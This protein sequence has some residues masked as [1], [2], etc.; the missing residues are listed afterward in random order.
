MCDS[1]W[2]TNRRHQSTITKRRL[3]L[4][5]KAL[6]SSLGHLWVSSDWLTS[7]P[8]SLPPLSYPSFLEIHLSPNL[9]RLLLCLQFQ[10][11]QRAM[12]SALRHF[13]QL[14]LESSEL[15]GR[16]RRMQQYRQ[17]LRPSE[18]EERDVVVL[19]RV[20]RC[21]GVDLEGSQV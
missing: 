15:R 18:N 6:C 11:S 8:R 2:I 20:K 3:S 16:G 9:V 12:D 4:R 14:I 1:L 21:F 10:R 19:A 5:T 7:V 13:G 17:E